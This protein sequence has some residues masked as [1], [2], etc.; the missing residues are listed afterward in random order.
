[1]FKALRTA[2]IRI[3]DVDFSE[4]SRKCHHHFQLVRLGWLRKPGQTGAM[5]RVH[6]QHQI[7]PLEIDE[8]EFACTQIVKRIP[9]L[10]RSGNRAL[11]RRFANVV[12]MGAR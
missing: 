10:G 8:L 12:A 3:R 4:S 6:C 2:V 11:I 5:P 1:M 9:A 7:K